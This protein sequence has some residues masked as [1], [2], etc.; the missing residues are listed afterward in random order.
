VGRWC[1]AVI[2]RDALVLWW[3][4]ERDVG[5]GASSVRRAPVLS[6]RGS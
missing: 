4:P 3:K 6:L 1:M 5:L 2:V